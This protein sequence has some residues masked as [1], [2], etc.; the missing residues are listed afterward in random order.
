MGSIARPPQ[1][2]KLLAAKLL[3]STDT[4]IKP[5]IGA[6][7]GFATNDKAKLAREQQNIRHR[8]RMIKHIL[9]FE[10]ISFSILSVIFVFY[11]IYRF[12]NPNSPPLLSDVALNILVVG[13]F[14]E[15]TGLVY[16]VA[17][18]LW[19]RPKYFIKNK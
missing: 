14:A 17:H 15:I 5:H 8:D 18:Y 10:Y 6:D 11:I 19:W 7:I 4:P 3:K 13:V 9:I 1:N 12:I 2:D 16:I